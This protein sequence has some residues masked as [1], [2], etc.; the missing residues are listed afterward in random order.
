MDALYSILIVILEPSS[1]QSFVAGQ[2]LL[3][4]IQMLFGYEYSSRS[5]THLDTISSATWIDPTPICKINTNFGVAQFSNPHLKVRVK[6]RTQT[7]AVAGSPCLPH[8]PICP[9]RT[10]QACMSL[11]RAPRS[12]AMPRL[13][14]TGNG[15]LTFNTQ[16]IQEAGLQP[17]EGLSREMFLLWLHTITK[18][19]ERTPVSETH[20]CPIPCCGY[21]AFV[22]GRHYYIINQSELEAGS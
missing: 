5:E 7:G 18:S 4:D 22:L 3:T 10:M 9:P 2:I 17:P 12:I 16:S 11:R 1:T 6:S 15:C 8:H 21:R 14:E 13:C 19:G 20:P